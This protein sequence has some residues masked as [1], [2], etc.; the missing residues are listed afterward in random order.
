MQK[1]AGA[2]AEAIEVEID[3]TVLA[4]VARIDSRKAVKEAAEKQLGVIAS[5]GGGSDAPADAGKTGGQS[6]T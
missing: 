3:E 5:L 2:A 1:T 6:E 4:F